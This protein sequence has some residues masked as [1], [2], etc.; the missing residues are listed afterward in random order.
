MNVHNIWTNKKLSISFVLVGIEYHQQHAKKKRFRIF[1]VFYST[2]VKKKNQ[3]MP[4]LS[5]TF[6]R[7]G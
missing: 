3:C 2:S 4:Q 5:R 7:Q 6:I 1:F